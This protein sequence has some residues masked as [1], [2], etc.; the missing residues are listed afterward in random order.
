MNYTLYN[1]RISVDN[2]V[3]CTAKNKSSKWDEQTEAEMYIIFI[4]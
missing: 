4:K 3:V 2:Y 1:I